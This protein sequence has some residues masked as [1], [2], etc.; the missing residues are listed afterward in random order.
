[1]RAEQFLDSWKA[2]HIN[3]G[4]QDADMPHLLEQMFADA[5]NAG[6]DQVELTR[7]AGGG[8]VKFLKGCIREAIAEELR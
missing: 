7:A 5:H 2:Q 4:T 1:M 3:S 6:V 8:M